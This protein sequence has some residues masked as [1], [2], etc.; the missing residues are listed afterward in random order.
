ML[1][2]GG[3]PHQVDAALQGFAI[4]PFRM[5]DVVGIDL[6]WRAR[7]LSGVG[8]DD[9]AVQVDNRL[10]GLERFGQKARRGYYCY[11]EGSWQ[12]EHDPE[13]DALVQPVSEELGFIRRGIG[14]EEILER[15]LLALIRRLAESGGHFSIFQQEA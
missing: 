6:E 13:V 14:Q 2:E 10:C 8:Q 1:L 12:A 5:Y 9:P 7:E 15:C 11:T 3:F 4:G